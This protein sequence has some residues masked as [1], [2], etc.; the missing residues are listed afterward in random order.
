MPAGLQLQYNMATH[1]THS[2]VTYGASNINIMIFY[3]W[4]ISHNKI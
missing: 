2:E 4:G 3:Y 1:L